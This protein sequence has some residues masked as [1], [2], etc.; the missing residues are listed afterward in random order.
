MNAPQPP[1]AEPANW[2]DGL[3]RAPGFGWPGADAALQAWQQALTQGHQQFSTLVQQ[4]LESAPLL[5]ARSKAQWGFALRQV[6]D[7]LLSLIHI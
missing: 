3:F 7:A 5:D 1:K 6:T 2:F 4:A